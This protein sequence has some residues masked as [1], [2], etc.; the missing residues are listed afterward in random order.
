MRYAERK[1]L[2]STLR[3][4]GW[5]Q[6]PAGGPL[7]WNRDTWGKGRAR[8]FMTGHRE[9]RCS[10]MEEEHEDGC[11]FFLGLGYAGN[12]SGRGWLT[13]WIQDIDRVTKKAQEEL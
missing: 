9:V 7:S 3:E 1:K 2:E 5:K 13:R 10:R 6:N 4:H 8:V 11:G 12:F